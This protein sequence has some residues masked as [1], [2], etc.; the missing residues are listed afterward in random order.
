VRERSSLLLLLSLSE[1]KQKLLQ[2]KLVL[3]A[4][5]ALP[6][7]VAYGGGTGVSIPHPLFRLLK[8]VK[9]LGFSITSQ[10]LELGWIYKAYM[11]ALVIFCT[12]AINILAGVNGLE[13]GQ[14]AVTAAAVA[15]HNLGSIPSPAASAAAAKAAAASADGHLF[16][17][18]IMLPLLAT[19]LGLLWHNWYPS[20]V[21]RKRGREGEFLEKNQNV[22]HLFFSSHLS[23][24]KTLE[25]F[26]SFSLFFS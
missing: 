21:V 15:A 18:F 5:A 12:N 4:A 17:L 8:N 26:L 1:Q 3:P 25:I 10:Y 16:S 22:P 14:T 19:S 13:A 6:L 20:D 7:L 9:F 24:K 2:V 23:K 11:A